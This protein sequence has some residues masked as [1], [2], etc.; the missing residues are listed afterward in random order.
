MYRPPV[1]VSTAGSRYFAERVAEGFE[2]PWLLD[3]ERTRFGDQATGERYLRLALADR[4]D[5]FGRDVIFVASTAT[6]DDLAE[7]CRVGAAIA[8]YGARR[9]IYAI[10]Y[11]GYS[12]MERAVKPGEVVTAKTVARQLSHIPSGDVQNCFLMMDLHTAGLVHYFEGECRRFELYAEPTLAE[13]IEE[14]ATMDITVFGSA[15]LG[16]PLWV[17]TFARRFGT[18]LALVRKSRDFETTKVEGVIGE[19]RGK[20]VI[21]Y[22]DMTRSAKSLVHAS[23]AYFAEG[24]LGVHVVLSHLAFN[25]EDAIRALLDSRIGIIIGTNSHPMSQHPLLSERAGRFMVKDVS[26]LFVQAI[27]RILE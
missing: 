23:D 6:D 10:P 17:E 20:V 19:V 24:A 4:A 5:L 22:D 1:I 11:F 21:I 18:G 7:V 14:V 16:R 25:N 8:K 3:T 13:A 15:D 9:V 2:D 12:T 26:P 27:R